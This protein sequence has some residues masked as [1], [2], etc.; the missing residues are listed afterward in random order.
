L[1]AVS[2][3]QIDGSF[4]AAAGAPN[5]YLVVRYPAG[6]AVTLPVNGTSYNVAQNLG[7]GTGV[8]M[9]SPR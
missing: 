9:A 5:G 4:T 8:K 7:L 6:A 1:T 2:T 3:G